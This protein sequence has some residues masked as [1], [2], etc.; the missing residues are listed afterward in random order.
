M[1]NTKSRGSYVRKYLPGLLYWFFFLK[2]K[3]TAYSYKMHS[4][5]VSDSSVLQSFPSPNSF[6]NGYNTVLTKKQRTPS[7]L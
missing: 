7:C 4:W 6:F 1:K 5:H 2:G 3:P